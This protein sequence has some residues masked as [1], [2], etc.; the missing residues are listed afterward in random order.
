MI[1]CTLSI[2]K[3]EALRILLIHNKY[4]FHGGEETVVAIEKELLEN[5][6]NTVRIL[7]FD[8]KEID[9]GNTLTLA[10]GL[11]YNRKSARIVKETI[12][13]FAPD[14]IHVHNLFYLASPSILYQASR[15]NVPVVVTLHN[16]RLV[17]SSGMLMRDAKP[18]E[19][20]LTKIFPLHGIKYKCHQ[21]S[22][23]K[24]AHLTFAI[25]LHKVLRTWSEK[26]SCFITLTDFAKKKYLESSLGIVEEKIFVKP[27]SVTNVIPR[28][29]ERRGNYFLF[30][31]RLSKEKGIHILL[32]A[33]VGKDIQV[34]I[35]GDGPY[36]ELVQDYEAHSSNIKYHGYQSSTFIASR[37]KNCLAVIVPSICYEGLPTAILEAFS[38][39]TPVIISD[40]DNLSKIVEHNFNGMHFKTNDAIDLYRIVEEFYENQGN[41]DFLYNNAFNTYLE[42][43]TPEINYRNLIDIY[44][45]VIS[46]IKS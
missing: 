39:G 4:K 16:Y 38:S 27:N 6:G 18:C 12:A 42:K 31:G 25:G 20:C 7:Y 21:N 30:V 35:I 1:I 3:T 11:I 40:I 26:V 9:E 19:L 33:F 46:E 41:Y 22:A 14:V 36:R 29:L 17:C 43:Y 8:N 34:E 45:K 24:T 23:L 28:S 37:L 2:E 32:D 44:Q 15:S 13:A 10:L 5:G